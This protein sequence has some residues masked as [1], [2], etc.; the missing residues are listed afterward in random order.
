MV[1]CAL[2]VHSDHLRIKST[3]IVAQPQASV[4]FTHKD[5]AQSGRG[6]KWSDEVLLESLLN[7]LL[8]SLLFWDGPRI[9]LIFESRLM[10]SNSPMGNV[11]ISKGIPG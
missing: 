4:L 6:C 3:V 8:H 5:E 7:V 1:I 9:D 11:V 2:Q 10:Y